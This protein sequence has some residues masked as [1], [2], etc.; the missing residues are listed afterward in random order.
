[1]G[2]TFRSPTNWVL[3]SVVAHVLHNTGCNLLMFPY[4][5]VD[6]D[7]LKKHTHHEPDLE[8]SSQLSVPSQCFPTPQ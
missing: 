5:R 3:P 6:L 8:L 4:I 2:C 7:S 1:M